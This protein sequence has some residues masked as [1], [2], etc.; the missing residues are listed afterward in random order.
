MCSGLA[1]VG[2]DHYGVFPLKGKLL[3]VRDAAH[4]QIKENAEINHI[5]QIMGLQHGKVYEDTKSLRYGH[6]MIMADQDH[7]GSHIKGLVIN[8]ISTFWPSLMQIPG[9]IQE[10]VT[11]I[12][13]VTKGK[14][15][16]SFFTQ[17]EYS[18]WKD[19][20][21]EGKGWK[22][23]YYKGLGTSSSAEAKIYFSD[24][25]Q[26]QLDFAYSGAQ[27][28]AD[29]DMA[30]NKKKADN[31]KQWLGGFDPEAFVDHSN[32]TIDYSDFIHRELIH[33]SMADNLRSIPSMVDGLKPGQ[34]KILFACFKRKLKQEIKVAQL[35]GYVS[36]HAAYHHGEMSLCG[37]IIGMAQDFV[38]SNN[39]NLLTPN[40]QFGTRIQGGKD[41]AS[42]RYVFTQLNQITRVIFN[43]LDDA[44]LNYLN[45]DGMSVEPGYYVPLI[46]M[47]LVNGTDGIGTGWS[48]NVPCYNP[49]D[50]VAN[51][52]RLMEG[53]EMVPMVPWYRG[54]T[55]TI[56]PK[57]KDPTSFTS[58]GVIDV[59]N[60]TTV[61]I[62]E[63]PVKKWTQDYKEFL[64]SMIEGEG[65][66]KGAF[67]KEFQEYH[68]DTK[69]H[70][71]VTMSA[72]NLELAQK[73][74]LHKK[75]KLTS[76]LST[77]NMHLF[78]SQ[79]HIKKY[80]T[81]EQIL[82]DFFELRMETYK[83]RKVFMLAKLQKEWSKLSNRARFIQMVVDGELVI[84]KKKKAALLLELL[85]LGFDQF[86]KEQKEQTAEEADAEDDSEEGP[87]EIIPGGYDYLLG[88][89]MWSLTMEK[90]ES[91]TEE[92][93]VK[94]AELTLLESKSLE[95]LYEE[96]LEGLEEGLEQFEEAVQL[97]LNK[98]EKIQ[99]KGNAKKGK[100]KAKK[101]AKK[102]VMA[103][104]EDSDELDE[105]DF[106]DSEDDSDFEGAKK[107][108]KK[109]PTKKPA[110][111]KAAVT[112]P[113]SAAGV[114][115]Q[116]PAY[117]PAEA[118]VPKATK[119]PKV[120]VKAKKAESPPAPPKPA[121][122]PREVSLMERLAQREMA[123]AG[124]VSPQLA[125]VS[126]AKPAARAK[127]KA[128]V[129]DSES[130]SD[131]EEDEPV[132]VAPKRKLAA[133]AKKTVVVMD[134]D[135]ESDFSEDE[136]PVASKRKLGARTKKPAA[137]AFDFDSEEES[138]EEAAP[139]VA[140]KAAPRAK[141][142]APKI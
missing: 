55:G 50:I 21:N 49:R 27:N 114:R 59:M 128:V 98:A 52:H 35:A 15:S 79:S 88:M 126:R 16:H 69:A 89:P 142:T 65:A 123:S 10:F 84:A 48:S 130:E 106:D 14:T 82:S 85:G 137:A 103:M 75:F 36:E 58:F 109:A 30:F 66:A 124:C 121:E 80:D 140:K 34:R 115:V 4:K 61:E 92:A 45:D 119:A 122:P 125:E 6:I 73:E 24:L 57:D 78:D 64:E 116:P 7:D 100:G 71:V 74:G 20:H 118:K 136:A 132:V 131:F 107:K 46:P 112:K 28:D 9:F 117:K 23:K 18:T 8:M 102:K 113:A 12:V 3:N 108:S 17:T 40:G 120:A 141:K 110:A 111:K 134:S 26:H 43:E 42:P 99:V 13:K 95:T 105:L 94:K 53:E 38:A 56:Q 37:T 135:S 68:T 77:S 2:R 31:R 62:T 81:P 87:A 32:A 67:I 5:K 29:F 97:A 76:S 54:F 33:F 51:L 19:A 96:N 39:L 25:E 91:L 83:E 63:L 90:I 104:I 22:I 86:G 41:A 101:A 47:S 11:P 1:V 139:V 127:K 129:L 138:E 44:V 70:F 72:E 93:T 133:R 60:D